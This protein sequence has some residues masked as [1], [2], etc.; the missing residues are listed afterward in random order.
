[1]CFVSLDRGSCYK[2]GGGGV[3]LN[4]ITALRECKIK[5]EDDY[6][7]P[8]VVIVTVTVCKKISK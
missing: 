2:I 6:G 1:V 3:A 7:I 5:K 8:I 4:S